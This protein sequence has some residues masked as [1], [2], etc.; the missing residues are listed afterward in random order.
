MTHGAI[1]EEL[2]ERTPLSPD[3]RLFID[4]MSHLGSLIRSGSLDC[5]YPI[6]YSGGWTERMLL[7]PVMIGVM[8]EGEQL[9]RIAAQYDIAADSTPETTDI[10]EIPPE[11]LDAPDVAADIP[12]E[13]EQPL[14]WDDSRLLAAIAYAHTVHEPYKRSLNLINAEHRR[15]LT[16]RAMLAATLA[17]VTSPL[18]TGLRLCHGGSKTYVPE[19]IM[20]GMIVVNIA[21]QHIRAYSELPEDSSGV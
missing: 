5:P 13:A 4:T 14:L 11:V 18:G 21:E 15:I 17:E 8:L 7:T 9:Q 19:V 16:R 2:P 1:P 3:E 6:E 20:N 12:S 10:T